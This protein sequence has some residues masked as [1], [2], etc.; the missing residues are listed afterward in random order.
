MDEK[1]DD[2]SP[3]LPGLW[4][5]AMS[6]DH[7]TLLRADLDDFA[8]AVELGPSGAPIVGCPGWTLT[9]LG[10][11]LGQ[12]HR[13]VLGALRTGAPP[14]PDPDDAAPATDRSELAAWLRA[15]S[16]RLLATLSTLDPTAPTWHP[17]PVEPKV[18][19]LWPRR[20]AQ[21]ASVHR[22]DA[23]LAIG[24]SP[25]IDAAFAA[26]GIDEYWTIM[27]PRMLSR[28]HR[29]TPATRLAVQTVDTGQRWVVDGTSGVPVV[30]PGGA[31]AQAELH[32]TAESLLLRLWG[33]PADDFELR[34]DAS[35]ADE[36]LGLGG[37]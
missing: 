37:A 23:Q 13:W 22:W 35:V 16:G 26:D 1:N 12:V 27:L 14:T 21:E 34:G 20:Q 2:I 9:D 17:F 3:I 33:R 8:M 6:L 19:G 7:L 31:T 24:M 10:V 36:W 32:G 4:C 29:S 25:T 15:G 18:A 28:E 5:S 30:L 11:H